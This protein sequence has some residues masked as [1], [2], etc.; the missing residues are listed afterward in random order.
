[1]R[2]HCDLPGQVAATQYLETVAKLLDDA[3][4]EER[5]RREVIPFEM[6]ERANVDD[7]V[8]FPEDIGEA[9]ASATGGEGASGRLR[10]RA[11]YCSPKWTWHLWH[12]GRSTYPGRFPYLDRFVVVFVFGPL[13]GADY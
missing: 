1:M 13:A 12:R 2:L 7:G 9:R 4:R 6:L 3:A 11:S 8:F 10:N 5:L